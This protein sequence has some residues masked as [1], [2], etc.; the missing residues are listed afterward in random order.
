MQC[1]NSWSWKNIFH[2]QSKVHNMRRNGI[3]TRVSTAGLGITAFTHRVSRRMHE[4]D[5][6]IY[7]CA[8]LLGDLLT[9]AVDLFTG[10]LGILWPLAR[11][12]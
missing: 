12:I 4:A 2:P 5:W 7:T 3:F 1:M 9:E 11:I 10:I 6:H 8:R